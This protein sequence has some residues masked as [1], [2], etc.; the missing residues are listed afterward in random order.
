VPA[1]PFISYA[2]EDQEHAYR[3]YDRLVRVGAKP[4]IDSVKLRPGENWDHAV[5]T[6][7]SRSKHVII[8]LSRHSIH[9]R[10]YIQR[11]I[12]IALDLLDEFPPGKIFVIPV[13]L[14]NTNPL[15]PKLRSLHWVDL[16][17]DYEYA[18]GQ[19]AATLRIQANAVGRPAAT[20]L[21]QRIHDVTVRGPGPSAGVVV[22][23]SR[24][25]I[26]DVAEKLIED[27]SVDSHVRAAGPVQN[28]ADKP[29][30]HLHRYLSAVARKCLF[31]E[32]HRG[33]FVHH[34]VYGFNRS[35]SGRIPVHVQR[36]LK[37]RVDLFAR[38]AAATRIRMFELSD[39]WTLNTLFVDREHALIAFPASASDPRLQF[40][41]LISGFETVAPLV[42]WFD[43][44]IQ[45]RA[46]YLPAEE[47]TSS[48][49]STA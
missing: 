36:T 42:S 18:F 19:I 9:K 32:Q 16:F 12:R 33:R 43:N 30:K 23:P 1:R 38:T 46:V 37:F 28:I 49:R 13:R 5:R 24:N 47:V 44:Y 11:E 25:A 21:L 20:S 15:Y 48:R 31:A 7:M 35:K 29:D 39:E 34:T 17:S 4:W 14:D 10:G 41:F 45:A 2:R 6:A 8:L 40:G 3:L 27:A 22:L 26:F